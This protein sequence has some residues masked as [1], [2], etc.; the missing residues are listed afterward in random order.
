MNIIEAIKYLERKPSG[1][2]RKKFK[3]IAIL[4]ANLSCSFSSSFSKIE[5]S[6]LDIEEIILYDFHVYKYDIISTMN[7][8]LDFRYKYILNAIITNDYHRSYEEEGQLRSDLSRGNRDRFISG[9]CAVCVASPASPERQVRSG[10]ARF[11]PSQPLNE[12]ANNRLD[13]PPAPPPA[14]LPQIPGGQTVCTCFVPAKSRNNGANA[15]SPGVIH[16]YTC[17]SRR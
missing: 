10:F 13:S 6:S 2:I 5:F 1:E 4:I 11:G 14:T 7:T 16:R 15:L 8:D 3:K 12:R 17:I 9:S